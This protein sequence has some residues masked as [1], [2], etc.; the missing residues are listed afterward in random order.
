MGFSCGI[1]GMPNVGKST[2]FNAL[3]SAQVGNS[4]FPF[5]TI[6]PNTGVVAIPDR[7]LEELHRFNPTA[8]IVPT[9]MTFIDIAGLIDGASK[10][11]GLGNRF[12][13]HIRE[14]DAI[15]HVVRCFDE[16]SIVHVNDEIS[17]RDDIEVINTELALADLETVSKAIAKLEKI[18]RA[19]DETSKKSLPGLRKALESLQAGVQVR[20]MHLTDQES[21]ALDPYRLLTRKPVLYV[22]NVSE[23]VAECKAY[24]AQVE[25]I[26]Q[27]E[28]AEMVV[29]SSRIE[30][31]LT[32]M[33][34]F[35][36]HE[37]LELL[38]W[39]E[40]SLWRLIHQGYRLLGLHSYFTA[41]P[42]EVRAW[43]IPVG[44]KAATAAGK[45][46]TDF[47]RG[48]IRAEVIAYEDYLRDKGENGA[49]AA[50]HL[51]LEGKEYEIVE[52]DV[53]RYR[54]NV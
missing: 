25:E 8:K 41:G 31:E 26:A 32:Q 28:G 50:G 43:T 33:P 9:Q 16:S 20:T 24:V 48:F 35:E 37:Y 2:L 54:F 21:E 38:G 30:E 47:E 14:T 49:K 17:P 42:K 7:R 13:A 46:H 23:D 34:E 1:V 45:I 51:R 36:R 4:N 53:V 18:A 39:E 22:A 6:E 19:G 12:L 10:G 27:Q 3:T 15:A 11:E 40:P 52:G 5:C 29:I 44:T